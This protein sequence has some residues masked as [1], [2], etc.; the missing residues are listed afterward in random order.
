VSKP[1]TP[2]L[3]LQAVP[4]PD[5]IAAGPEHV[6]ALLQQ[7]KDPRYLS[8]QSQDEP[9]GQPWAEHQQGHGQREQ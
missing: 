9:D 4:G 3:W 2:G 1:A 7:F 8:V 6:L 5:G